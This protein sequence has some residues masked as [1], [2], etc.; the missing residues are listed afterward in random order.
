MP[1]SVRIRRARWLAAHRAVGARARAA[2]RGIL[3]QHAVAVGAVP[4]C[5]IRPRFAARAR[6]TLE[7]G[8]CGKQDES[9]RARSFKN[10]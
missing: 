10:T 9:V 8:P 2:V 1:A 7:V 5:G 4:L 6:I 3:V